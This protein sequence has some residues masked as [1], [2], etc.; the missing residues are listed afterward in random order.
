MKR[1]D[2]KNRTTTGEALQLLLFLIP[3]V[4]AILSIFRLH[5]LL[6]IASIALIFVLVGI[7][8]VTHGHENLWLFLVSTPAFV[9]INLHILFWYPDLLEYFCTNTD[10]PFI[11]ITAIIVEILLFL[12]AE[13]VLVAFAGR[14]IWRR[15]Y[16]LKLPEYSEYDI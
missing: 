2:R 4:L 13:E 15:Q 10:N 3:I 9:P 8:P 5:V 12:G 6:A 14:L 11:L 7:L 16:R 1:E